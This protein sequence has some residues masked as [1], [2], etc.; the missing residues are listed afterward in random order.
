[1]SLHQ[2]QIEY[3]VQSVCSAYYLPAQFEVNSD[4]G[5]KFYLTVDGKTYSESVFNFQN[6]QLDQIDCEIIDRLVD[7]FASDSVFKSDYPATISFLKLIHFFVNERYLRTGYQLDNH[8]RVTTSAIDPKYSNWLKY[9]VTDVLIRL[10]WERLDLPVSTDKQILFTCDWDII[11]LWDQI[12]SLDVIK[13]F[14][15]ATLKG[16]FKQI[17]EESLSLVYSKRHSKYNYLLNDLM[18]CYEK[19]S[20]PGVTIRNLAFWLIRKTHPLFDYDNKFDNKPVREFVSKLKE[21]NVEFGIHP[22]Y[23]TILEDGLMEKQMEDF[24]EIFG[25]PTKIARY[26]Y[27]HC[28]FPKD[29]KILGDAGINID[30]SYCFPD[31]ILFRGGRSCSVYLWDFEDNQPSSVLSI[32][33]TIMDATLSNYLKLSYEEALRQSKQK[34]YY[35]VR[36]G[37]TCDLL[38]HNTN[39]YQHFFAGNYHQA[40]IKELRAYIMS[41]LSEIKQR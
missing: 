28:Q 37:N 26:H 17:Y 16:Q 1:M 38:W 39:M 19:P 6:P 41:L 34:I 36:Y 3:L 10:F 15:R 21:N 12:G 22:N 4:I 9:P 29:L 5:E 20:V 2:K 8:Q 35:A 23:Q 25:F 27:L 32:P 14:A 24:E 7:N 11:N 18:Y 13:R 33:L 40:L 30:Y 31:S